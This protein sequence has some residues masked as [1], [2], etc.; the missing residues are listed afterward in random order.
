MPRF[1]RMIGMPSSGSSAPDQN[2]SSDTEHLARD[3]HHV[4]TAIG[5]INV[6]VPTLEK[7]RAITRGHPPEGVPGGVADDI[8]LGLN[9]TTAD[10]T[11][12]QLSHQHLADEIA[13]QSDRIDRQLQASERRTTMPRRP[14]FRTS[15]RPIARARSRRLERI[16]EMLWVSRATLPSRNSMM[17]TV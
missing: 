4:R 13:G 6:G 9:D 7:Q 17:L 2:A 15:A 3:I 12:R 16:A 1:S 11:F 14:S 8:R 5:E 10:D